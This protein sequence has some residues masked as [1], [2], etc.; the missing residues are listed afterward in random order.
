MYFALGGYF[1]LMLG[2]AFSLIII[3]GLIIYGLINKLQL[4]TCLKAAAVICINIPVAILY[5]YI[6]M[7]I[8]SI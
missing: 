2:S 4:K 3:L 7:S 6:G 5:Y 1:L 8:L